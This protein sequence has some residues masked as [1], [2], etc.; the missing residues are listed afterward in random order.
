VKLALQQTRISE[1]ESTVKT[2]ATG[3][4]AMIA[5]VAQVGGMGKLKKFYENF[6]DIRNALQD[7]GALPGSHDE[8]IKPISVKQKR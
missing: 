6:G 3:H 2:L 7:A 8:S 1:L 5:A 4:L